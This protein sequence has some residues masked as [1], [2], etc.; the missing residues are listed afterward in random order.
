MRQVTPKKR[1]GQHFLTD[2]QI[3]EKIAGSLTGHG[4]YKTLLE[5]GPGEGMLTRYL[6]E[7][8]AFDFFT[9]EVEREAIAAITARFPSLGNRLIA[10]D[11]LK[12]DYALLPPGPVGLVGNFPYNISGR[13]LFNVF[14]NRDRITEVVG[15]FQKEVAERVA[16]MPGSKV[17]GILSV[18]LQAFYSVKI[19]FSVGNHAF[20][21]PPKVQSAVLRLKRNERTSLGCDDAFFAKVVKTAF[22]QR[23]KTLRNGLRPLMPAGGLSSPL[24]DKR[25]EQ[26]GVDE[27]IELTLLL[28]SRSDG[29]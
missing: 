20:D 15:M 7:K 2:H 21:P 10:C 23:R 19:L 14:E 12:F 26:L 4:G 1:Y 16:T 18:L 22:N 17:Y 27:F 5:V 13:I 8:S 25:A 29:L 6:I 11:F 28:S 9:V 24:L 3:A